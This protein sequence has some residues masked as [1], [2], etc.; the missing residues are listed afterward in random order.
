MKILSFFVILGLFFS[1]AATSRAQGDSLPAAARAISVYPADI[2]QNTQSTLNYPS[3]LV[4]LGQIQGKSSGEFKKLTASL[5]PDLQKKLWQVIR[6]PRLLRDLV[7]MGPQGDSSSLISNYP[8]EVQTA[9]KDLL[10]NNFPLLRQSADIGAKAQAQFASAIQSLPAPAQSAFQSVAGHSEIFQVL[11]RA[12]G[13]S[14]TDPASFKKNPE[15][16]T[17]NAQKLAGLI[18]AA[19]P[20]SPQKKIEAQAGDDPKAVATL[21]KADQSFKAQNDYELDQDPHPKGARVANVGYTPDSSLFI[22][23]GW[24]YPFWF[25]YP[26]WDPFPFW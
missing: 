19:P 2:R 8:K 24:A 15:P 10:K 20:S 14:S 21:S 3:T 18:A 22:P 11:N 1:S 23:I 26:D 6:Y 7:D 16:L 17:Q 5:S 12:L 4:Q 9:A 25:G 13:L